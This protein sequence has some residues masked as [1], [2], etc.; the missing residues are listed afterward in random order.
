MDRTTDE[1]E[2]VRQCATP[3]AA[4]IACEAMPLRKSHSN[5]EPTTENQPE[6]E[7]SGFAV[8]PG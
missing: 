6:L 8:E 4:A 1:L 5:Q 2:D 3:A 7:R